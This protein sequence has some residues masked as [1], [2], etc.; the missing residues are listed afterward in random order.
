MY[1]TK[2]WINKCAYKAK[3]ILDEAHESLPITLPIP[4][5]KVV[6]LYVPDTTIFTTHEPEITNSISACA[7]RDVQN[8]WT[9]L[10]NGNY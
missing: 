10:V 6:Q 7:T 1:P 8:G 4:I 3:Q 5:T 2:D 9:I